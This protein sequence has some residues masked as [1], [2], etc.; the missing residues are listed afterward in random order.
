MPPSTRTSA[1]RDQLTAIEQAL[2]EAYAGAAVTLNHLNT[3]ILTGANIDSALVA[4]HAQA[5]SAM[6][7]VAAKLGTARRA[8]DVSPTLGDLI[9]ADLAEQRERAAR[10]D[11]QPP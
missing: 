8:K 5:I 2:V 6:V 1:A 7:R 11:A 3:R 10:R 4:A 9:K